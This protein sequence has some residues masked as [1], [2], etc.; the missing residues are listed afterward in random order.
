L[1]IDLEKELRMD[2]M[3]DFIMNILRTLWNFT[4][5]RRLKLN[6]EKL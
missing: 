1:F 5:W 4:L 3:V 6:G 2:F